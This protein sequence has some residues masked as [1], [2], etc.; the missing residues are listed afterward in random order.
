MESRSKPVLRLKRSSAVSP[1]AGP[2]YQAPALEKGLDI[3]EQL[4][5]SDQGLTQN[6][7]ARLVGRSVS[8][9][10]RV[11]S[12]LEQ[13]GYITRVQGRY[14]L[15]LRL[16]QL[17]H[18]NPPV[19]RLLWEALPVMRTLAARAQQSCHIAVRHED[20]VLVIGQ[21]NAPT[22]IGL[23]VRLGSCFPVAETTSGLVLLA[24]ES[25]ATVEAWLKGLAPAERK[26][27]HSRG[28]P[29]KLAMIHRRGFHKEPSANVTGVTNLSYPI[30]NHLGDTIAALTLLYLSQT[31][32]RT[33]LGAVQQM[34]G[35]AARQ[36][37]L[38]LGA[39]PE[40]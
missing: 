32:N 12:T 16:F 4:S 23:G 2:S 14:R 6:D 39:Q 29:D 7:I 22:P 13:R 37:G 17:A 38:A 30:R 28:I 40:T 10:F 34:V 26:R 11:L 8:E 3:L 31:T 18:N 20:L 24:Y 21:V 25:P 1:E 36:I 35:D 15:S 9:I 33:A 5:A 27:A 19:E